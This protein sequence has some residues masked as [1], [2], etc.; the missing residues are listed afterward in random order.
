MY[1]LSDYQ[2]ELPDG[3]IAETAAQPAHSAKMM[4]LSKTTGNT[5]A[6]TT[7]WELDTYLD[8][9]NVL[10]FNNSRVIRARIPLHNNTFYKD[11]GEEGH[12]GE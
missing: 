9:K 10:F 6:E 1:Q 12:I 2:F 5:L 4:I 3:L 11:N 8:E 7:F